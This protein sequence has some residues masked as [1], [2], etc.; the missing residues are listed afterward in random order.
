MAKNSQEIR[1]LGESSPFPVRISAGTA[2]V[3]ENESRLERWARRMQLSFVGENPTDPSVVQ[4]LVLDL[5][6]HVV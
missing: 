2:P 4:P 1:S 6:S 5:L 3:K